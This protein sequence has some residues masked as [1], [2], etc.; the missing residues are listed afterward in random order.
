MAREQFWELLACPTCQ[1]ELSL[2]E[3]SISCRTCG[4]I[5]Q[6]TNGVLD[7]QSLN[8]PTPR[9][10]IYDDPEYL[11]GLE[12]FPQLHELHYESN[13]LSGRL[14]GSFKSELMK[15]VEQPRRPFIDV[16][17]A[18]GSGFRQLGYPEATIGI[19][20]SLDLL[21]KC[22][23]SFPESDC[24]CCDITRAP[25]RR[26]SFETVFSMGSLEHIFYLEAF[27][28]ALEQLLSP[29]GRL[30]VMIPTEGGLTWRLL[31]NLAHLKYARTLEIN[32]KHTVG[33]EHI[34]DA[35]TVENVLRK[36]FV[37]EKRRSFPLRFGGIN[38][39][40]CLLYRLRR[41]L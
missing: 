4:T 30:Y 36:F 41:R 21:T 15:L 33:I 35:T 28:G 22:K 10:K 1:Q 12:K 18:T 6:V 40:F 38:F 7:F 25:F 13:S 2:E 26:G 19:D 9:P 37:I 24:V 20:I 27:V 29:S 31:R 14:E 8:E 3:A 5:G 23:A 17:C 11:A 16:G 32:Y 39:N 34:N